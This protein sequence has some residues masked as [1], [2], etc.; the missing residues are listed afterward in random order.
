MGD[1]PPDDSSSNLCTTGFAYKPTHSLGNRWLSK[2]N[3]N[4]VINPGENREDQRPFE[5]F[6]GFGGGRGLAHGGHNGTSI[7]VYTHHVD[8]SEDAPL[9]RASNQRDHAL[10]KPLEAVIKVSFDSNLSV[11]EATENVLLALSDNG[12]IQYAPKGTLAFVTTTGRVLVCVLEQP[13]ITL[14][15]MA[16][17]LGVTESGV[18][19]T[20]AGLVKSGVIARTKVK[21]R[22]IYS[23]DKNQARN[24]PDIR[25]YFAA[26]SP[27]FEE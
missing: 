5:M 1:Q 2:S 27:I 12:V 9:Q 19:K 15:E 16:M 22:N 14:R 25:R 3:G 17:I 4:D 8:N 7:T 20:V 13:Q 21:G 10:R 11:E 26:I 24:H 6:Q 18:A 23:V